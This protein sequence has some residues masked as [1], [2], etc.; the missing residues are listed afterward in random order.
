MK[1][2]N[3]KILVLSDLKSST[4]ACLKSTV[5]LAKMIGGD[6]HLFH[7]KKPTDVIKRDSQLSAIGDINHA[8]NVTEKKIKNIVASIAEKYHV[9]IKHVFTV[10][11]VKHEISN[12]INEL[13]PDI[14]VLGKR[15]KN[16]VKLFGD[17]M[18]QFVLK[19]YNGPIMIVANDNA[20]EPNQ[21]LSLGMLNGL[22]ESVD[23][24]LTNALMQHIQKPL[25]SFRSVKSQ[26]LTKDTIIS[27]GEQTVEYVFE[28]KDDVIENMSS[29]LSK[30]NVNL[31]CIDRSSN[32]AK[33]KTD[34]MITD[35]RQVIDKFNVSL[36]LTSGP[37]LTM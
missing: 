2:K 16:A 8:Y 12:H 5:S 20:I 37:K 7:V 18:T 35:L 33:N 10:G 17:S 28:H 13:K 30:S 9:K 19:T 36:L 6:I 21:L 27:N 14:I 32:Q 26:D 3:Y 24:E 1:N 25:R 4:E 31:L 34:L 29:Y 11:N 15:K 22:N 23:F